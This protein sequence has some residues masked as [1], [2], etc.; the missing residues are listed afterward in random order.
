MALTVDGHAQEMTP[1]GTGDWTEW[2]DGL[3]GRL[4]VFMGRTTVAAGIR[5]T[6]IFVELENRLGGRT[7]EVFFNPEKFRAELR[8][9]NGDV[10]PEVTISEDQREWRREKRPGSCRVTIPGGS[11]LR[12]RVSPY[13]VASDVN[14]GGPLR[15]AAYDANWE[16]DAD[17][18]ADFVLT[19]TLTVE[20]PDAGDEQ[21]WSGTLRLPGARVSWPGGDGR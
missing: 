3:R 13:C 4:V 9:S 11:A 6:L 10:I 1:I 21:T 14:G 2:D 5:E 8:D 7:R 17:Q 18:A 19:A 16:L 12:L 15:L 20:T